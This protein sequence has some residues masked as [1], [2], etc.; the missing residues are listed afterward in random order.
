VLG[1]HGLDQSHLDVLG[2][3]RRSGTPYRL[4]AGEL[5]RR[6]RVTPGA[7]TQ[8]VQAMEQLG[9]VERVREEPDRR[10]V[11]VQLTPD[12]LAR[13]DAIFADVMAGDESLLAGLS[14]THRT[15]L[16]RSLRTWLDVLEGGR[17]ELPRMTQ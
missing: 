13:L 14:P 9:L 5:S 4:T 15:S 1:A 3:L 7:T 8:R 17:S 10:T 12:G 2:T 11:H 6:C 16:E